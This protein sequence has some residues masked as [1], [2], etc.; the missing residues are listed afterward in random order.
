MENR[1]TRCLSAWYFLEVFFIDWRYFVNFWQYWFMQLIAVSLLLL[2]EV[3]TN[4]RRKLIYFI[5]T[6]QSWIEAGF[7]S[8]YWWEW[9]CKNNLKLISA[10]VG[11]GSGCN[12]SSGGKSKHIFFLQ[13]SAY[14]QYI[15]LSR[16]EQNESWR[17][18]QNYKIDAIF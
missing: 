7:W 14:S 2:L 4:Q 12:K 8:F 16:G 6:F 18:V 11:E 3:K 17:G 13:K 10:V 5:Y 9:V 1:K 15:L